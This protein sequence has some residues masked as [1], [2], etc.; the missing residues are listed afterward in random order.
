MNSKNNKCR[1]CEKKIEEVLVLE[2]S[3]KNGEI[4]ILDKIKPEEKKFEEDLHKS[5]SLK[6]GTPK[7]F[8]SRDPARMGKDNHRSRSR[9]RND[10]KQNG[11]K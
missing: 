1:L 5:R 10:Y 11:E 6:M 4:F 2:K 9:N 3:V 8:V 7:S